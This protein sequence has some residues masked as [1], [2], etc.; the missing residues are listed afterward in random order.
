MSKS[1]TSTATAKDRALGLLAVRWRSRA[2]L[3]S[4]LR[5]AGFE[6]PEIETAL[7]DLEAAGLVD[8][9]RFA[10]ELV[11]DRAGRRL[12]GPRAIRAALR[13]KG[14]SADATERAMAEVEGDERERA[15]RLAETRAS[16]LA[17]LAPEAAYRRLVGLLQRRGYGFDLARWAAT[18]ALRERTSGEDWDESPES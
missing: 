4:R 10:A 5:R 8:D 18:Q 14:V 9:E 15:L 6:L 12:A 3:R 1:S 11:R 2:E 7:E 13:E 16:R 17:G